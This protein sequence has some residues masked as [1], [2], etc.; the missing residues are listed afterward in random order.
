[1]GHGLV[2]VVD[3]QAGGGAEREGMSFLLFLRWINLQGEGCM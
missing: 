1:M 3:G 2:V